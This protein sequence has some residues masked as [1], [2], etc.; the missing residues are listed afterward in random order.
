MRVLVI[1]VSY[2]FLPWMDRCLGSLRRS[3]L[4]VD[5]IVIDNGSQDGTQQAVR[6]RFPE[7][8][9][10]QSKANIGF[11]RANN[12]GIARALSEG[13]DGVFLLNQDAWVDPDTIQTLARLSAENPAYGVL[14]PVHLTAGRDALER[15]FAAYAGLSSL[16]SLPEKRQ[17]QPLPFVDAALWYIPASALRQVGG[18]SPLFHMYGEDKDFCNRLA[19]HH[20]LVGYVPTVFGVHD[21]ANRQPTRAAFLRS[22]ATYLL[23]EYA[24]V[25]HS[26][27]KAFAMGVLATVKK[28]LLAAGKGRVGLAF[29]YLKI[30]LRLLR[31][32][33]KVCLA[34]WQSAHVNLH[35]YR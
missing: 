10:V 25:N 1:I 30:A 31:L 28:G 33:P 24:N 16:Q 29:S 2:N 14:S 11:G 7:V 3:I 20:R 15:G 34:R 13:Y 35:N 12:I 26:L 8:L 32:T 5:I 6:E 23:S 27:P 21:R 18:F 9:L 19:Y 4:P 22:E 17:I